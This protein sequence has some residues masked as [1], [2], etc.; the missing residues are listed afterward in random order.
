MTIPQAVAKV[1][2]VSVE[3]AVETLDKLS[4]QKL[5]K[6]ALLTP[7]TEY[8]HLQP[9]AAEVLRVR[10]VAATP[11]KGTAKISAYAMLHFCCLEETYRPR[12]R[13][14][15]WK[16]RFKRLFRPGPKINYYTEGRKLGY[17]RIDS[18]AL[19]VN[20]NARISGDP[21]RVIE[22]CWKDIS[23]RQRQWMKN[24]KEW[25]E[26]DEFTALIES[27]HFVVTVITAFEERAKRIRA[28]MRRMEEEH[29]LHVLNVNAKRVGAKLD[30]ERFKKYQKFERKGK[31]PRLPPPM[32]VHVIPDLFE[33]MYPTRTQ[34]S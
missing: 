34:T 9:R 16:T 33:L 2:G 26:F 20:P 8:F 13:K 22:S 12:I 4:S 10:E 27:G 19:G 18:Q 1:F 25:Q 31:P 15:V 17:V 11:F 23:K 32:E 28:R 6:S 7:T 30:R 24:E 21:F 14:D 3:Q 5:I 29:A